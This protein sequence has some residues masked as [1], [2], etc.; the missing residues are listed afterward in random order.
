MLIDNSASYIDIPVTLVQYAT[1]FEIQIN[2]I[3]YCV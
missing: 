2:I 3:L 1:F